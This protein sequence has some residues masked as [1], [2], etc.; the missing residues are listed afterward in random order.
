MKT[1]PRFMTES[2][3]EL[4]IIKIQKGLVRLCFWLPT[5]IGTPLLVL[6]GWFVTFPYLILAGVPILIA[7]ILSITIGS[8]IGFLFLRWE[9]RSYRAD[10]RRIEAAH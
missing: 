4:E 5:F 10:L 9:F 1:D 3:R 6:S 2:E 7:L 8:V